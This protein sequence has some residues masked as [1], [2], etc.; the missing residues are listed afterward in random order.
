M[1]IHMQSVSSREKTGR[2]LAFAASLLVV[3]IGTLEVN[4]AE[5]MAFRHRKQVFPLGDG[6]K[7]KNYTS[8]P[9]R[10][11]YL[12]PNGLT[13]LCNHL[14]L[15]PQGSI[16]QVDALVGTVQTYNC[17]QLQ[18]FS[19]K[20]GVGVVVLDTVATD[21]IIVG[22]DQPDVSSTFYDLGSQPIGRNVYPVEYHTTMSTPEDL[23]QQCGLSPTAS[24]TRFDAQA[25]N[26]LTHVCSQIPIW[27]L[28]Q[29]ES[30]LVLE[31]NGPVTCTPGHF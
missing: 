24:V 4:P 16:L 14:N 9:D 5:N 18:T 31:N 10:S 26:V 8:L 29:G 19:L 22:S 17:G 23:C 27:T 25:G 1:E 3:C 21:G 15:S 30:V 11:P 20:P 2:W 28:V 6:A 13:T 7:G 12:G